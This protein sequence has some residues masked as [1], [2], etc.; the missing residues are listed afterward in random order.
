MVEL[1]LLM[2]L[3]LAFVGTFKLIF[4]VSC[5]RLSKGFSFPLLM[6]AFFFYHLVY[7]GCDGI[8]MSSQFAF[9]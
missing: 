4:L 6:S 1:G 7:D 8:S 5:A 3:F 9:L 2:D